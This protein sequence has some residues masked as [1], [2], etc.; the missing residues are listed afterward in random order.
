MRKEYCQLTLP[1]TTRDSIFIPFEREGE[2]YTLIDTAGIR[3]KR[4]V[5]EKIEK[6]SIIKAISALEDSHVVILV[7]DAHEGVTEQDATLL[8]MIAD[9][10]ELY[11]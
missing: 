3:R 1:G 2:Q 9:K 7:L 5:D 8:G 4:S 6:F 11:S 10:G